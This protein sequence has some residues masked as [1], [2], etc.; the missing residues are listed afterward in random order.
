MFL[1]RSVYSVFGSFVYWSLI[2]YWVLMA[3][4]VIQTVIVT[5]YERKHRF[6]LVNRK[7]NAEEGPQVVLEGIELNTSSIVKT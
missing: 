7:I 2:V 3:I 1:E 5:V 6:V 4:A